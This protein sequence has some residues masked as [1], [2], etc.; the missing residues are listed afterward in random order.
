MKKIVRYVGTPLAAVAAIVASASPAFATSTPTSTPTSTVT[1][2]QIAQLQAQINQRVS[3]LQTLS[4]RIQNSKS[5]TSSD[6]ST[7]SAEV[8]SSS[9]GDIAAMQS[10][11]SSTSS[12]T[13]KAQLQLA[14]ETL[15]DVYR[16]YAVVG[17]QVD[18][19]IMQDQILSVSSELTNLESTLNSLIQANGD[20]SA[21]ASAYSNLVTVVAQAQSTANA[22][23]SFPVSLTPTIY[24]TDPNGTHTTI[25]NDWQQVKGALANIKTAR[26]DILTILKNV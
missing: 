14:Y 7:L 1:S 10:L 17:P 22:L 5:L 15:Y 18:L 11:L 3:F 26:G 9:S 2:T 8:G 19:T 6:A 25:V 24:N 23:G 13:T 20:N 21:A 12:I 16:I 4:G